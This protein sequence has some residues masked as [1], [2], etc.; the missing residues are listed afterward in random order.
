[1]FTVPV[2]PLDRPLQVLRCEVVGGGEMGSVGAGH[3]VLGFLGLVELR[4]AV[5]EGRLAP[6]GR[7]N[8]GRFSGR[9]YLAVVGRSLHRT[10]NRSLSLHLPAIIP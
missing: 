5:R 1:M 6:S 10:P 2:C 8:G 7:W 4:A 9:P 3:I